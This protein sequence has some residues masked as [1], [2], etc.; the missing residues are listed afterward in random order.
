MTVRL[1]SRVQASRLT[2]KSDRT[3]NSDRAT[4]KGRVALASVPPSSSTRADMAHR[5]GEMGHCIPLAPLM[6]VPLSGIDQRVIK[7]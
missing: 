7:S 5:L 3:V 6:A 2:E 1:A 4:A